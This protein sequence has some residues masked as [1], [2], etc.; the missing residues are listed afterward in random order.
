MICVVVSPFSEAI[1]RMVSSV[2][3]GKISASVP[4]GSSSVAAWCMSS[5]YVSESVCRA[6]ALVASG[7]R[8]L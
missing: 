5:A 4:C 7:L 3:A 1:R 6:W 8:R 2:S